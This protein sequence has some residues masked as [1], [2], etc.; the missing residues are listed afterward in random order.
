MYRASVE[1]SLLEKGGT[2]ENLRNCLRGVRG[3]NEVISDANANTM[4]EL[5]VQTVQLYLSDILMISHVV[6][7]LWQSRPF[8]SGIVSP[9]SRV[10]RAG[11]VEDMALKE[12]QPELYHS[13]GVID[14]RR[15][16]PPTNQ[17]F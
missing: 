15:D 8:V 9:V 10:Q 2:R 16:W 6:A 7:Y 1:W 3:V 17:C 4:D 12:T 14:S 5:G 11:R 13:S